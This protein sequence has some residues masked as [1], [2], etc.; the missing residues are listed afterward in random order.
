MNP[1]K[2]YFDGITHD[3]ATN[4]RLITDCDV[5]FEKKVTGAL[6]NCTI[7]QIIR[8]GPIQSM[9]LTAGGGYMRKR[10]SP[11]LLLPAVG[12]AVIAGAQVYNVMKIN[13]L[14]NNVAQLAQVVNEEKAFLKKGLEVFNETRNTIHLIN[15]RLAELEERV[16]YIDRKLEA[17]PKIMALIMDYD[18]LFNDIHDALIDIDEAATINKASPSIMK[19]FKDNLWNEPASKWSQLIKCGHTISDGNL[20][21][22][23]KFN[24]PVRDTGVK[25]MKAESFQ[26]WNMTNKGVNAFTHCLMQYAGPKYVLANRTNNCYTD[27]DEFA[28]SQDS[29][30]AFPCLN[31][32]GALDEDKEPYTKGGCHITYTP[33]S[34]YIQVK[35]Y[36]GFNKIYCWGFNISTQ[37]TTYPCPEYPFELPVSQSFSTNDVEYF[38]SHVSRT[39]VNTLDIQMSRDIA[40]QLNLKMVKIYGANLT[41]FDTEISLIN[42]LFSRIGTNITLTQAD[43][44]EVI[45]T[46][47]KTV[48]SWYN[49]VIDYMEKGVF[50]V[51]IFVIITAVAMAAPLLNLVVISIKL[52]KRMG[53]KGI[54]AVSKLI[55]NILPKKTIKKKKGL[56]GPSKMV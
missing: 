50:V 12:V 46:P 27:I 33:M 44:P 8:G 35:E 32:N 41:N 1:C 16:D 4:T 14:E 40:S 13:N 22:E 56:T 51:V 9:S 11:A 47:I 34:R 19:L 45:M 2:T 25:I 53:G 3:N 39:I 37:G 21:L 42:S 28:I 29:L 36:N 49:A 20:K 54:E 30:R 38:G 7:N 26:F 24:V 31:K 10:R 43:V 23:Y 5:K 6:K 55:P 18:N 17:Y 52:W 48:T 15:D